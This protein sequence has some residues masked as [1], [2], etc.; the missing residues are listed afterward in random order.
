MPTKATKDPGK[1]D[2]GRPCI[3]PDGP[4]DTWTI[5]TPR[6]M[7]ARLTEIAQQQGVSRSAALRRVLAL[8]IYALDSGND[9]FTIEPSSRV[10]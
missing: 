10:G 4:L 6:G 5:A 7:K 2:L 9:N 3:T 1:K 8:G